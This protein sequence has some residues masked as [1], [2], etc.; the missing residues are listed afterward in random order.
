M[1]VLCHNAWIM[2]KL[3]DFSHLIHELY[4]WKNLDFHT[5]QL[6]FKEARPVFQSFLE[7]CT[8]SH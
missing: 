6:E 8:I 4:I 3:T 1:H 7:I 5:F 2:G